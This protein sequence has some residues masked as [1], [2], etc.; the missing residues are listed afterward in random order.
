MMLYVALVIL[1]L[2]IGKLS[3]LCYKRGVKDS[4]ER[5]TAV[6]AAI[7][8]ARAQDR[9][10]WQAERLD[11]QRALSPFGLKMLDEYD[12]TLKPKVDIILVH[13]EYV[14]AKAAMDTM[15]WRG[16]PGPDGGFVVYQWRGRRIIEDPKH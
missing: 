10:Q 11:L 5:L 7:D 12:T 8:V 14:A 1:L 9:K 4:D 6:I 16:C 15:D 2:L 13:R 3:D